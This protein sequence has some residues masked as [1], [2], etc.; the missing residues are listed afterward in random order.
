MVDFSFIVSLYVSDLPNVTI[1][2]VLVPLLYGT[3]IPTVQV[4]GRGGV[5]VV[6]HAHQSAAINC[7]LPS[8]LARLRRLLAGPAEPSRRH[9][10][11]PKLEEDQEST[12][13]VRGEFPEAPLPGDDCKHRPYA[14]L[15]DLQSTDTRRIPRTLHLSPI[16]PSHPGLERGEK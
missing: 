11:R 3:V 2:T 1:S 13:R 7:A 10:P 5:V 15:V 12:G 4:A 8:A 9:K 16:A 6:V 14:F